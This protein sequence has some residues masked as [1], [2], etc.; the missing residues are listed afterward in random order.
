MLRV[1]QFDADSENIQDISIHDMDFHRLKWLDCYN[2]S[3]EELK[4]ISKVVFIPRLELERSLDE[5]ERPSI[6]ELENF[7]MIIFKSPYGDDKH[8]TTKSFSILISDN[9]VVTFSKHKL[10]P[11]EELLKLEEKNK[12]SIFKKGGSY[13]AYYLLEKITN[14]YFHEL[15]LIEKDI[16]QVEN[17][18]FKNPD[19]KTVRRIFSLKKTLIYFHKALSA[20][21]EVLAGIQD[22]FVEHIDSAQM[23]NFRYLHYDIMQL[24]DMVSTYRDILTGALDIY[25]SS[26]SNNL[27]EVMKRM[28]ALGSLVLVPTLITGLYG[29]NFKYMPEIS[30]KFGYV[31][32]WI[33]IIGTSAFLYR[34]FK[35]KKWL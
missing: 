30:W 10:Q 14:E 12:T 22:E 21:R 32:A 33:L 28:T 2:P 27:N 11:I 8:V 19:K 6:V 20:N 17:D 1:L 18:V 26:V 15:N 7:S 23:K 25:L 9:L 4:E 31:F 29:M 5:N 3:K 34:Y 13:L 16:D 35:K 24:L